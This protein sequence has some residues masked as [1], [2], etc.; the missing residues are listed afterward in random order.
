MALVFN[1]FTFNMFEVFAKTDEVKFSAD[2]SDFVLLSDAV[3]DVIQEIRYYSTYNFV[4]DRIDC[5][6]EP[7]ALLSKEA[8]VALKEASDELVQKGYKL[9][10]YDAYRPQMAVNNFMNW[11]LDVNDIR[12]KNYFYPELDKS[13]LFPQGYI[14][15]PENQMMVVIQ[16]VKPDCTFIIDTLENLWGNL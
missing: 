1:I 3:P 6:E 7:V 16:N 8:V 11:A 5:Y 2:S 4:G 13:V 10:I 12:M 15:I 9:K 14:A